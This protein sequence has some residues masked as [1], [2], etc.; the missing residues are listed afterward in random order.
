MKI[1]YVRENSGKIWQPVVAGVVALELAHN[2]LVG[3]IDKVLDSRSHV[4]GVM[5]DADSG[6]ILREWDGDPALKG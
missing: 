4:M 3:E 1:Q 5:Y 6:E 2:H